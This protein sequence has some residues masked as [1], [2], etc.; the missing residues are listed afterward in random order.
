MTMPRL[1]FRLLKVGHCSHPEC[2]AQRGGRWASMMFP[3]LCGLLR[4][5]QRGWILFD[6]G[7]SGHFLTA[8]A[9]FPERLYRWTTPI[10][11]PPAEVLTTQ[12]QGLGI[13]PGDIAHV[14]IS[15]LHGDHI[16]G[17]RDFPAAS[18][19]TMRAEQEAMDQRSRF[20]NLR[21]GTLPALLPDDFR[22]R[23][24][25]AE[26]AAQVALPAELKP[27]E[28][29]FDLF[30]DGS[31]LAVHLPG[32]SRGQLGIVFRQENDQLTFM[33]ADACWS[34]AAL[35]EDRGP[36]WIARR[37]LDRNDHYQQTFRR[38]QQMQA[39]GGSPWLIPSHCAQTWKAYEIATR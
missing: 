2:I 29:G 37:I 9:P 19:I 21:H 38:L 22:Q 8:T 30:G 12:L 6:T 25:Y 31:V 11:L 39:N 4:H 35:R 24:H 3:A 16:A 34:M 23:V 36:T 33:S 20:A 17:V 27:F 7:Y 10:S 15:H 18:L 5:P 28:H 26:D 1:Q 32:H 14:V 13:A